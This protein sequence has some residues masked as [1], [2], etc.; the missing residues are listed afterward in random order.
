MITYNN[1]C[2]FSRRCIGNC[3]DNCIRYNL[4]KNQ[5]KLST[6]PENL[7]KWKL[8]SCSKEDEKAFQKLI[9]IQREI[10]SFVKSGENLFIYSSICGNGKTSWAINLL[11]NYVEEIWHKCGFDRKTLFVNVPKLLYDCKRNINS[12]VKNLDELLNDL[13]KVDLV[14]WDDIGTGTLSG[15]EHQIIL[16]A[17]DDR[18]NSRKSNIF[19]SN[20]TTNS[21]ID[22]LGDRLY[23]RV[24]NA[25]YTVE[26]FSNDHRGIKNG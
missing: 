26:L 14:V 15:Y 19:T 22:T 3:S 5:L 12:H 10:Y 8:L 18:L 7:W 20:I 2:I 6:L 1:D 25:S 13:S 24:Y 16:Q 11:I 23:S 17:I 4:I 21:I 9:S